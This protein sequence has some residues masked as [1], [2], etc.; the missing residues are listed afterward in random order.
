MAIVYQHKKPDGTVFYI[1]IGLNTGR[2]FSSYRRNKYWQHVVNKHGY[3]VNILLEDI[4]IDDAKKWEIYLI[5][6]LGRYDIDSGPLVNMTDGGDGV[7]NYIHT[8]H[9]KA[10]MSQK[11]KEY[12]KNHTHF[13]EGKKGNNHP[14]F[15]YKHTEEA[16]NRISITQSGENNHMHG[17]KGALC[18]HSKKVIDTKTGVIY[19]SCTI[20]AEAV[21]QKRKTLSRKLAGSRKNNTTLRYLNQ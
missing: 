11:K 15:G 1:G 20:A 13:L 14:A 17:K 7:H 5:D 19:D 4:T 16:K 12:H 10:I 3:N 6:L 21:G 2:A 9:S 18:H 8:E